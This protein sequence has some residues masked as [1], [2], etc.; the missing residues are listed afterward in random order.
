MKRQGGF[1]LGNLFD[2][3]RSGFLSYNTHEAPGPQRRS[4]TK[5][6]ETELRYRP[7]SDSKPNV[8]WMPRLILASNC[9]LEKGVVDFVAAPEVFDR[10]GYKGLAVVE[11]DIDPT[12]AASLFDNAQ[13][14]YEY[15]ESVGIAP[16]RRSIT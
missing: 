8:V 16:A 15:L 12:G 11:E 3:T 7:I 13:Q 9:P 5:R 4:A 1:R 2:T 6:H 14:S 10:T